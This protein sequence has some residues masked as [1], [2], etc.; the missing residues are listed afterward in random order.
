MYRIFENNYKYLSPIRRA[1]FKREKWLF[2]KAL[3]V[4]HQV[5]DFFE[6]VQF[7]NVLEFL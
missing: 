4:R 7:R 6:F 1:T 5:F 2:K 3:F